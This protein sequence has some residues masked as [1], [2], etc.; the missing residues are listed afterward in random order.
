VGLNFLLSALAMTCYLLV[1]QSVSLGQNSRKKG[2]FLRNFYSYSAVSLNFLLSALA[3][4]CYLLVSD[5]S[6]SSSCCSLHQQ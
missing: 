4:T 2:L 1:S 5:S 3:M 6:S